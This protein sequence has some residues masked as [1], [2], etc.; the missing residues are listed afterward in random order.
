M[1]SFI[2]YNTLPILWAIIILGLCLMPGKD[3]PSVSIFEFDKFAHFGIYLILSLLMYYGWK[4]QNS[5]LSLHQNAIL[6]ILIITS[7]YG[8]LVEVMQELFTAD[9]HFDIFDALA[10]SSGATVGCVVVNYFHK[11]I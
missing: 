8:F 6:K 11:K 1:N 2:K 9:R 5:F 3:L 4:K 7:T 10:N